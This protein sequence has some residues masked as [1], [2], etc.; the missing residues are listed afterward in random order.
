[1]MNYPPLNDLVDK[2]NCRY[3]LVGAIAKRARRLMSDQD[4]VRDRKPVS[5]AVEE[6]WE[7]KLDIKPM[8]KN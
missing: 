8:E 1:M 5:V 4:K 3:M 7:G 6:M 2:V